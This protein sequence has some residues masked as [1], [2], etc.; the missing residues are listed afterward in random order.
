MT[1][2]L[3]GTSWTLIAPVDAPDG[4]AITLVFSEGS[5]SGYAGCNRYSCA[6]AAEGSSLSM[7]PVMT[8]RMACDDD[9]MHAEAEFLG[10]LADCVALE[11]DDGSLALLD[12]HGSVLLDFRSE[13]TVGLNGEWVVNGLH[14]PAREAVMSVRGE[15]LVRF[16]DDGISGFAGCNSFSGELDADGDSVRIGPL[17]STR[18][19]CGEDEEPDGPSVMEQEAALLAAL[20]NSVTARLEGDRLIL[21]RPDGGISV[22]LHRG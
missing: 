13:G 11:L 10:R 2:R 15:L 17:M 22:T 12:A 8:T 9:A 3:D 1:D 6:Y 16:D 20:E 21:L 4:V 7:G 18:R 14:F 19:F 5:A